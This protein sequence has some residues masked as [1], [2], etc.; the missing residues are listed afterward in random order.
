MKEIKF[1]L[2]NF[3]IHG[4]ENL[5]SYEIDELISMIKSF[6]ESRLSE[7]DEKMY[8]FRATFIRMLADF[9]LENKV[10]LRNKFYEGVRD[11]WVSFKTFVDE[12]PED[13]KRYS[14]LLNNTNFWLFCTRIIDEVKEYN[15]PAKE[16]KEQDEKFRKILLELKRKL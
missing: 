16:P 7:S 14:W 8:I 1:N 9:L 2:D 11:E 4:L 6:K 3:S 5:T 15:I 13:N 12:I 10:M